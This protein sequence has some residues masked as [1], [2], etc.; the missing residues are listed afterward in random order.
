MVTLPSPPTDNLYKFVAI[1]GLVFI[2]GS[3][4]GGVQVYDRMFA[5]AKEESQQTHELGALT[6]DKQI[7]LLKEMVAEADRVTTTDPTDAPD[8]T[9]ES[10]RQLRHEVFKT[11]NNLYTG[12]MNLRTEL[13]KVR[14]ELMAKEGERQLMTLRIFAVVGIMMCGWGFHRWW[15]IIQTVQD[16]VLAAEL[17]KLESEASSSSHSGIQSA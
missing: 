12:P 13:A 14:L 1:A 5:L 16:K 11:I 6:T 17:K 2:V 10:L 15:S 7:S 8:H 3:G 4:I 9:K